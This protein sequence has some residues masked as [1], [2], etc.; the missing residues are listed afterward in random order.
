MKTINE[1]FTEEEF[2][3]LLKAKG[4]RR[5]HDCLLDWAKL[6]LAKPC[7]STHGAAGYAPRSKVLPDGS[8]KCGVCGEIIKNP[9]Q[10]AIRPDMRV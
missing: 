1:T 6:D 2:D 9:R 7:L 8:V 4:D 5:W 3:T 10:E